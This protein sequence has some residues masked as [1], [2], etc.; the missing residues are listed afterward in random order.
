MYTDDYLM[1]QARAREREYQR[2]EWRHRVAATQLL[3]QEAR[4]RRR[5]A[6]RRIAGV[7]LRSRRP[8]R[9]VVV[10]PREESA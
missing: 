5:E 2:P 10:A 1:I 9:S 7:F 6:A 4:A 3:R 8:A